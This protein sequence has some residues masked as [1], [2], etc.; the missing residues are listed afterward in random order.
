MV[1]LGDPAALRVAERDVAGLEAVATEMLSTGTPRV[2]AGRLDELLDGDYAGRPLAGLVVG[3]ACHDVYRGDPRAD[4]LVEQAWLELLRRHD[5]PGL[6][7]AANVRANLA[8]GRGDLDAAV[9]WWTRCLELVD[10]EFP[11]AG[12]ARAHLSIE[13]YRHGDLPE[14]IEQAQM[15]LDR[16]RLC[17]DRAG[18]LVP[19]TY[20]ILYSIYTGAFR[21]ADGLLAAAEAV[22]LDEHCREVHNEVPL[23]HSMAGIL[24]AVRHDQAVADAAFAHALQAAADLD[25]P[26]Y[27]AMA[28][29]LRGE[30][31]ASWAPSRSLDD[32]LT[33][34]REAIQMGDGW[35]AALAWLAEGNARRAL[36]EDGAA[37]HAYEQ[38]TVELT[39]PL[40]S[41]RALLELG[42]VRLRRGERALARGSLIRALEV[43]DQGGAH[44]LA[45][46]TCAAL[47]KAERNMG[48]H[49]LE[50]GKQAA[51]A[52]GYEAA[53]YT[54]LDTATGH[55]AIEFTP[56]IRIHRDGS[57]VTFITRHAEIAVLTLTLAHPNGLD[58]GDLAAALWPG[59][60][61]ARLGPRLR[62]LLWQIRN[63]L[64]A[65]AWRLVRHDSS[66]SID[67]AGVT[68]DTSA[69]DD[70][71]AVLDA[72]HLAEAVERLRVATE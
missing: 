14:A 18:E 39:N 66:I 13:A 67:L 9:R 55:L 2:L 28:R 43:F 40:E 33:A 59:A 5:T 57:R 45:A 49:W 17:G 58:A 29:A 36:G 20:L 56:T 68:F 11:L 50:R 26:W 53:V 27:G 4:H 44:Y 3:A 51:H 63:A 42:I 69:V 16:Q 72:G 38:A 34:R 52:A 6:G 15:A 47:V 62:T 19:L 71:A 8:F 1:E 30:F 12:A 21:R 35:W 41:A 37:I 31:T 61:A 24:A 7:L 46:R 25:T 70:I 10:E 54:F 48:S 23:L 60:P 22:L 64:G 65:D 32:A